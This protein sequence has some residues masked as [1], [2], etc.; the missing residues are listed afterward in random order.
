VEN[1]RNLKYFKKRVPIVKLKEFLLFCLTHVPLYL[2]WAPLGVF[3]SKPGEKDAEKT[4]TDE[5][6]KEDEVSSMLFTLVALID[7]YLP[8]S[9]CKYDNRL[10]Y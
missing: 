8:R 3:T 10:I 5:H 4:K 9:T 2:E 1:D 6:T 7:M